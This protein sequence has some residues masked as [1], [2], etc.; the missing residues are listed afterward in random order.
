[1]E[2]DAQ[3]PLVGLPPIGNRRRLVLA[4]LLVVAASPSACS[5]SPPLIADLPSNISAARLEFDRRVR[6]RFPV[7]SRQADIERELINEGFVSSP[8]P[9]GS[10]YAQIYSLDRSDLVCRRD[11][12]VAW[13]ADETQR[14]I[15]IEGAYYVTCL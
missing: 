6:D 14:V 11:W 7:G 5:N 1:M 15:A 8:R 13:S 3:I 9:T 4:T 2:R 12:Q 10:A